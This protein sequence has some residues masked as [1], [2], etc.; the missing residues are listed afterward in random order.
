[1]CMQ[2]TWYWKKRTPWNGTDS[3]ADPCWSTSTSL[4]IKILTNFLFVPKGSN[5]RVV[6]W[7]GQLAQVLRHQQ[8]HGNL[9]RDTWQCHQVRVPGL[10]IWCVF[11]WHVRYH[12]CYIWFK[13]VCLV[14]YAV[15]TVGITLSWFNCYAEVWL[16]SFL[17]Q[18]MLELP[19]AF[20][21]FF[22]KTSLIKLAL[23]HA[24]VYFVILIWNIFPPNPYK[25]VLPLPRYTN[26]CFSRYNNSYFP[27]YTHLLLMHSFVSL[28]APFLDIFSLFTFYFPLS[29]NLISFL[30]TSP[31]FFFCFITFPP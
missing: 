26:L 14:F 15:V 12:T 2:F 10:F 5:S 28:F 6:R 1:M 29:V 19:I 18:F 7:A 23:C 20:C 31:P 11:C 22:V 30:L 9:R 3:D 4:G 8:Q 24:K 27:R 21:S 16:V 17:L 13:L 25:N